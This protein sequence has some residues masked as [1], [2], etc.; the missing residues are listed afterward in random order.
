MHSRAGAGRLAAESHSVVTLSISALDLSRRTFV[1]IETGCT[2]L[3]R[4]KDRLATTQIISQKTYKRPCCGAFGC[5]VV[6]FESSS[7]PDDT[8]L[9]RQPSASHAYFPRSC[10]CFITIERHTNFPVL[11]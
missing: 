5:G 3:K 10:G 1:N 2:R 7:I 8:N 4:R 6:G 9:L 11:I